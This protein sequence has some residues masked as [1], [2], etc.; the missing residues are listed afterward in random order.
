[1]VQVTPKV[2]PEIEGCKSFGFKTSSQTKQ[3]TDLTYTSP[4]QHRTQNFIIAGI[5]TALQQFQNFPCEASITVGAQQGVSILEGTAEPYEQASMSA[6]AATIEEVRIEAFQF[7]QEFPN[8]NFSVT[9]T[10]TVEITRV[11]R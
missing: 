3:S 4:I 7:A 6:T 10:Q 9:Y 8:S 2:V 1:M 5:V 11:D